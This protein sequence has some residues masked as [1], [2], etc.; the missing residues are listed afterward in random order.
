MKTDTPIYAILTQPYTNEPEPADEMGYFPEA[1]NAT[2]ALK[3]TFIKMS[4]VKFLEQGGARIVPVSY[5]LDKNQLNQIL[6]QVNGIYIPGDSGAILQ[7]ERYLAGV[8]EVL[9]WA[10]SHNV[11]NEQHF[12]VAAVGYGYLALMMTAIKSEETIQTMPEETILSSEELNLRLKPEDTYFFDGL[13]LKE[14]EAILNNITFFNEM[15]YGIPLKKFLGETMLS[16]V[17]V[18]VATYN[19]EQKNQEE[20][21]VAMVEGAHFPFFGTAFSVEKFQFNHDMRIEMDID[22]SK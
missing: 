18:P 3:N 16:Q 17:F 6:E 22:H 19:S 1:G 14:M 11:V 12:P 9:Q 10:Q 7:N 8:R 4:H 13:S 21:F 2:E 20:E 15:Q 5:K